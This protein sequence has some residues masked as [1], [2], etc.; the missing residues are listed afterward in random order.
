M[1][2]GRLLYTHLSHAVVLVCLCWRQVS[3]GGA[4]WH[5]TPGDADGDTMAASRW[6]TA[7]AMQRQAVDRAATSGVRGLSGDSPVLVDDRTELASAAGLA[8]LCVDRTEQN[9]ADAQE[10]Q[11]REEQRREEQRREHHRRMRN[12]IGW[13]EVH[14]PALTAEERAVVSR[15]APYLQRQ[16]DMANSG[17]KRKRG[18]AAKDPAKVPAKYRG[19]CCGGT[20][21]WG[22][23]AEDGPGDKQPDGTHE[24]YCYAC[25]YILDRP[26]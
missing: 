25:K 24:W 11:R 4:R 26:H 14:R 15:V 1:R 7:Y 5:W 6:Y 3:G 17:R 16:R 20:K 2:T 21:E 8:P 10:E 12:P 22:A 9:R 23:K 19:P 13:R 18:S